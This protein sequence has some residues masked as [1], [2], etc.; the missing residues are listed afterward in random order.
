MP[1]PIASDPNSRNHSLARPG[2]RRKEP[3]SGRRQPTRR[4]QRCRK[5]MGLFRCKW[6][7]L[8]I[9]GGSVS[10][11]VSVSVSR[12]A[13]RP[14]PAPSLDPLAPS[15]PVPPQPLPLLRA[16][17][18]LLAASPCRGRA[19]LLRSGRGN[20]LPSRPSRPAWIRGSRSVAPLPP[21]CG[22]GRPALR[23]GRR[24]RTGRRRRCPHQHQAST[25]P[26]PNAAQQR[27]TSL[28]SKRSG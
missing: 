9:R 19:L 5:P 7:R 16:R 20:P 15:V 25:L 24:Q 4:S 27:C 1:T 17:L 18:P 6:G 13:P 23:Q 11:S 26:A 14:L 22:R 12:L 10:A 8:R 28:R 2:R 21:A 3:R